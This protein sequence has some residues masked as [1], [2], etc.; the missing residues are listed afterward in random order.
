MIKRKLGFDNLGRITIP[1]DI[2]DMLGIGGKNNVMIVYDNDK[3]IIPKVDDT[4]VI[5]ESI[6]SLQHYAGYSNVITSKEYET[7]EEILGK[8]RSEAEARD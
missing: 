6:D 8:L 5:T 2:R 3:L 4:K 7:L 1:K